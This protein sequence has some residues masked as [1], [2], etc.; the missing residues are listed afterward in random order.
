MAQLTQVLHCS[1]WPHRSNNSHRLSCVTSGNVQD[2]AAAKQSRELV[3]LWCDS[4]P[5]AMQL[6]GRIFPQGLMRF[7]A[8]PQPAVEESVTSPKAAVGSEQ[9]LLCTC[10][11][12]AARAAS[13][14]AARLIMQPGVR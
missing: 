7:L 6:L 11:A 8:Q 1:T 2:G 4:S 3:A 14:F 13:R 12:G 9:E 10:M 5:G